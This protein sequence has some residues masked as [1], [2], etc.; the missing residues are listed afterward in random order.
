[1][2]DAEEQFELLKSRLPR[3]ADLLGRKLQ[4]RLGRTL[5]VEY[6]AMTGP[7][8][9]K[10]TILAEH[11]LNDHSFT[12]PLTFFHGWTTAPDRMTCTWNVGEAQ[13]LTTIA[14]EMMREIDK[15]CS[16]IQ[17]WSG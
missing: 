9:A 6:A 10:V 16:E 4:S 11:S 1:M 14:R 17:S 13:E 2:T 15:E 5:R 7:T 12:F 8:E 3:V